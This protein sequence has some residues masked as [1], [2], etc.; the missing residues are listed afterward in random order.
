MAVETP[1]LILCEQLVT[2][3]RTAWNPT[4]PS[5]V[6]R[7]YAK[8][9]GTAAD[10]GKSKLTG[11]RVVVYPTSYDNGPHTRKEDLYVHGVS[12]QVWEKYPDSGDPRV[13]WMDELVDFTFV[14]IVQGFD[15]SREAPEWNLGLRTTA[16][17]T[18]IYDLTRLL[19]VKVFFSQVDFEFE[20][21]RDA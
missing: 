18:Q 21:I 13:E 9:F 7:A 16:T 6:E 20:E 15:F 3:L 10:V 8:R 12:V 4:A 5:G 19:G 17:K 11:R 14:E 2:A 1:T